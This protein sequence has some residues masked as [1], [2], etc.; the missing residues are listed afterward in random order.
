MANWYEDKRPLW[1][2]GLS[3]EIIGIEISD[4]PPPWDCSSPPP[5]EQL[6]QLES[7]GFVDGFRDY[8]RDEELAKLI[9]GKRIAYVCPSPH[10]KDQRMGHYIDSFD[11]VVRINQSFSMPEEQWI[12]YGKRTDIL[13]NCLNINKLRALNNNMD[14]VRALKYIICPMVSM[15]DI[16]RVNSFLEGT[17]VPWQNVC[18]GFLFKIFKEVGTT[19]NTG[20]TGLMTLLHYD[21]KEIYVTGMTFFNMN[22][23]GK[24]YYD[25]YH[26]SA[27]EYSNFSDTSDKEP[28][29]KELRMDIHSQMPQIRYFR[30]ILSKHY[31]NPL[32]IDS[33]LRENFNLTVNGILNNRSDE[34]VEDIVTMDRYLKENFNLTIDD[35]DGQF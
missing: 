16:G 10:L 34:D 22:T 33:Y 13:M 2:A 23:F 29:T 3:N 11:L 24:V 20:L 14:Y 26:D 12:D 30:K 17:G 18:D 15:W 6:A 35:W 25:E 32:Y 21:V 27:V 31:S 5:E 8:T 9:E 28:S 19:A 4:D 7:L 1:S